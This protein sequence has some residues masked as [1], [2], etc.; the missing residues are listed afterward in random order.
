MAIPGIHAWLI[1]RT[2][3]NRFGVRIRIFTRGEFLFQGYITSFLITKVDG[4]ECY[5]ILPFSRNEYYYIFP[6][7]FLKIRKKELVGKNKT[8]E[9][10][11]PK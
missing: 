11:K 5:V 8:R 10:K 3:G 9:R 4:Y 7:I 1:F 2:G 6:L